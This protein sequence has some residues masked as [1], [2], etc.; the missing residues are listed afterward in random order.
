MAF[1]NSPFRYGAQAPGYAGTQVEVDQ[2][3]RAFMLGVYNNMV[4]GLGISGLVALGLNMA[5]TAQTSAGQLALTPFGQMLYQSPLKWVLMLAPLA[6]IFIFSMRM[7]RMSAS[8]ARLTFFAFAA[9]MGASMST[10][11]LVFTGAS[12]VRVFFITAATFGGLSLYG[13]TTKRSLS[14][15]GSFLIMGLIGLI[16]ASLVNIF[17][18]SS[19]LQFAISVIGVLI[20]AGLTAYDTQKLKEMYLYS[21]FDAEGAAKMSVNGALT[22]YLDFINMFQF[23]LSLMGDR[24]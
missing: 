20:F 10:L 24:R 2:G 6:F 12:V 21:G 13:Y 16:I 9:V 5:A 17:L 15:M 23:L 1:D 7:D 14:G 3:L 22:L 11:L 18:A 8:S 4:I 19:A